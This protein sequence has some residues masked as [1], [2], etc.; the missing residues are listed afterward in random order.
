MQFAKLHFMLFKTSPHFLD[1]VLH[2]V[3]NSCH[4]FFQEGEEVLRHDNDG[5]RRMSG[6]G[7]GRI[8]IV[9]VMI[10]FGRDSIAGVCHYTL[11][12]EK[13]N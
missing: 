4:I 2:H 5:R 6:L 8:P 7:F 10:R 1:W 11:H 12:V 9:R 13:E 3:L